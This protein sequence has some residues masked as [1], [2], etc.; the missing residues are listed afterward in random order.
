LPAL[1]PA[2]ESSLL[3]EKP[4]FIINICVFPLQVHLWASTLQVPSHGSKHKPSLSVLH[5]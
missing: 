2:S 3:L 1:L 4:I 5:H